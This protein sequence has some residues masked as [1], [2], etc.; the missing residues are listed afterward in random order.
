VTGELVPLFGPQGLSS[1]PATG[2]PAS[3]TLPVPAGWPAAPEQAAYHGLP[4]AIVAKIAPHTEAD[5]ATRGRTLRVN[6]A[7]LE[8]RLM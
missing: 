3:I 5:R 2:Q 4:G 7:G 8:D 6:S 1:D